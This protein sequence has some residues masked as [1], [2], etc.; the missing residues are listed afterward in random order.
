MS[1]F[2]FC[3]KHTVVYLMSKQCNEPPTSLCNQQEQ[4][5][6]AGRRG[7]SQILWLLWRAARR[8]AQDLPQ[9]SDLHS[10]DSVRQGSNRAALCSQICRVQSR[11]IWEWRLCWR[12]MVMV[13]IALMV[14]VMVIIA[15]MVVMVMSELQLFRMFLCLRGCV[16]L[17][18]YD[19]WP[20]TF[21]LG[22]V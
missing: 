20:I 14:M 13:I 15:M 3:I 21:H 8:F 5:R 11:E 6:I 4:F 16:M 9:E 19:W 17:N 18:S 22:E 10:R 1:E 12:L 2:Q 7:I